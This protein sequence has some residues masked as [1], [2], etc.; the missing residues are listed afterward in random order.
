MNCFVWAN[1]TSI[2]I[3]SLSSFTNLIHLLPSIHSFSLWSEQFITIYSFIYLFL[4]QDKTY[5]GKAK[6]RAG[7]YSFKRWDQIFIR[8]SKADL[9]IVFMLRWLTIWHLIVF[10]RLTSTAWRKWLKTRWR[11]MMYM[12]SIPTTVKQNFQ[13]ARCGYHQHTS[14]PEYITP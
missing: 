8:M 13:S 12:S 9:I 3:Y 14:Q 7:D 4:F 11:F 10:T 6:W 2:A 5:S 1:K